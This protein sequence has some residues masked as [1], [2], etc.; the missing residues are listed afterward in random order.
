MKIGRTVPPQGGNGKLPGG[1]PIMR[2]HH[3]DGLNTA[4]TG[5]PVVIS[6]PSIYLWHES[7]QEF[8]AQFIVIISVTVNAV[9]LSPTAGVKSTSPV[10]ENHNKNGYVIYKNF[11]M[12][13]KDNNHDTKYTNTNDTNKHD[14]RDLHK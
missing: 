13:N 3:K 6:E 12:T 4:R 5:K 10:T 11:I 9:L 14:A 2:S 1:I 7:Q 8:D